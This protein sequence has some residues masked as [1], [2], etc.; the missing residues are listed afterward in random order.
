MT[1]EHRL[2]ALI[3][4]TPALMEILEIVESLH[5]KEGCLCAGALRN[6]LWNQLTGASSELLSDIDVIYYDDQVPYEESVTLQ[7]Q[8]NQ[9]YPTFEWEVK[10]QYYMGG[11]HPAQKQY[12]SVYEGI[13]HFPERCTA[14]G[15]R[16]KGSEIELIAPHG[17]HDLF[18]LVV[19]PSP[20]YREQPH[21]LKVYQERVAKKNWQQQWPSLII[22]DLPREGSK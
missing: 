12:Q 10:N 13:A 8:L 20:S 16:K 22:K 2:R 14:I 19:A 6:T 1:Y 18:N 9:K 21:F 7:T 5:L 17:Y 11:H 4:A 15:A 3:K